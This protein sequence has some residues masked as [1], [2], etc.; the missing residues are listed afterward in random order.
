LPRLLAQGPTRSMKVKRVVLL[1]HAASI[2]IA[3]AIFGLSHLFL[4]RSTLPSVGKAVFNY[5]VPTFAFLAFMTG[6][7]AMAARRG[8]Y[9]SI[10]LA[11]S[12]VAAFLLLLVCLCAP[13]MR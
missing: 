1:L 10:W 7:G 11:I 2:V 6:L 8:E 9:E 3:Y 13:A 12:T 4:S 5:S